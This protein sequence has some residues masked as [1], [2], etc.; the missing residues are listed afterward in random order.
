[1]WKNGKKEGEGQENYSQDYNHNY[2]GNFVNDQREGKGVLTFPDGSY[3]GMWQCGK[4]NGNGKLT[5]QKGPLK[6]IFE[7]KWVDDEIREGVITYIW[8]PT[9][10][11]M[12][13]EGEIMNLLRHGK[14]RYQEKSYQVSG[15]FQ[16]DEPV[17]NFEIINGNF[18]SPPGYRLI[19]DFSQAPLSN[20]KADITYEN[21]DLYQG[22][23]EITPANLIRRTKGKYFFANGKKTEVEFNGNEQEKIV[24]R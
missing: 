19:G 10:E 6:R 7:G 12:V 20:L 18:P 3:D 5:I 4:M 1:M 11:K 22:M 17:G 23:V 15:M 9:N 13:Y 21:K 8:K 24:Y 2:R 14:G 16:E